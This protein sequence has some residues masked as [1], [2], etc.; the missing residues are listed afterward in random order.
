MSDLNN[1][2]PY[3]SWDSQLRPICNWTEVDLHGGMGPTKHV[4]RL[5][6]IVLTV[7]NRFLFGSI[8]K[9]NDAHDLFKHRVEIIIIVF[10]NNYFVPLDDL[11][12]SRLNSKLP[13]ARGETSLARLACTSEEVR[14]SRLC[15]FDSAPNIASRFILHCIPRCFVVD[16]LLFFYLHHPSFLIIFVQAFQCLFVHFVFRAFLSLTFVVHVCYL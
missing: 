14:A 9:V 5:K 13:S 7:W 11:K 1:S 10:G 2:W 16:F 4:L 12:V 8:K 3:C 6:R 15:S